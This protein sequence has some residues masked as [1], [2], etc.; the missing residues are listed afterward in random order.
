[1]M[2]RDAIEEKF[3][4]QKTMIE[5]E[6]QKLH[7]RR[8]EILKKEKRIIKFV[9]RPNALKFIP[10]VDDESTIDTADE[11][12]YNS[13][14]TESI[15]DSQISDRFLSESSQSRPPSSDSF[16]ETSSK[17]RTLSQRSSTTSDG[18]DVIYVTTR[19][20]ISSESSQPLSVTDYSDVQEITSQV[21]KDN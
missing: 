19:Y 12:E 6:V 18:S 13:E 16:S 7:E 17:M 3:R 11:R 2:E 21:Q 10:G 4:I 8:E 9:V 5:E 20:K 1:M 14:T 15:T